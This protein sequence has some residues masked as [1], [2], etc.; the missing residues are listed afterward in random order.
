MFMCPA[1]DGLSRAGC[2]VRMPHVSSGMIS[3]QGGEEIARNDWWAHGHPMQCAAAAA[4]SSSHCA[5]AQA[6]AVSHFYEGNRM[7]N[8]MYTRI[9]FHTYKDIMRE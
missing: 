7:H 8:Y 4:G 6:A 2:Y 9:K 5:T 1:D 3:R